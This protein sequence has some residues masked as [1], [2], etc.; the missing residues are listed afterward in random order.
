[1]RA[2]IKNHLQSL[3][4]SLGRLTKTPF[5]SLMT[6]AVLGI[7]LALP[8]GLHVVLKNVQGLSAGWENAAQI[9]LF[10]K[11]GVEK[12]QADVLVDRLQERP[13]IAEVTYISQNEALNEFREFSGLGEVLNALDDNPLPAVVVVQPSFE[14]SAP[15]IVEQLLGQLN[16]LPEVDVAQLDMEW[17]KRLFAIMEIGKR[18]VLVLAVLLAL[19]VLLIVGN[20]IKLAIQSRREEIEVQKLIG[21]TD[22]FICR[23]FLYSGFWH[24]LGGAFVAWLMVNISLLM[25][26]GPVQRLSILYN[27]HFE[28]GY[29]DMLT[30][31]VLLSVGVLLGLAGARVSVGRHLGEIEP[32]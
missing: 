12:N 30:S 29:L 23:P 2:Y 9:S 32:S 27:S 5:S 17:V 15:T 19:S 11:K 25:L 18:G 14:F 21:A 10:L 24:G 22:S 7:A 6:I 26:N 28:L 13:E 16:Q 3:L 1:M 4:L 31:F 20:T 8:T